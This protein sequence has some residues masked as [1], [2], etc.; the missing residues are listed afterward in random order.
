MTKNVPKSFKITV[1]VIVPLLIYAMLPSLSSH[2]N[3][4]QIIARITAKLPYLPELH[5]LFSRMPLITA[6]GPLLLLLAVLAVMYY[7]RLSRELREQFDAQQ[8]I[9][10]QLQKLHTAVEHAPLSIVITDST[11]VIEY[12]NPAFCRLT[13]YSIEE[14]V[15]QHTRILKGEGAGTGEVQ[16]PEHYREL[17]KTIL[18]G[19]EWHGEFFNRRK[20]NTLFW[21]FASISPI[22]D[23]N[24][25]V[26]HFVAVKENITERKQMMEGLGQLAYHDKL[27]S[28]PNRALFLDRLNQ[29][30]A[31]SKC[32]QQRFAVLFVDLDG[33]KQVNDSYGHEAGDLVLKETA[34]RLA[35]CL[36]ATDIVARIGGDEFIIILRNINSPE[37]CG[38][39]AQKILSEVTRAIE[40]PE[41]RSCVIGSSIGISIYPEDA[42]E[43]MKL[44]N[45]ADTAM[46]A[47]KRN[48]KNEYRFYGG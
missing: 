13:G 17:W 47:V 33:F 26:T 22:R 27:T 9:S 28:L 16:P 21:E 24:G 36:R 4:P 44:V 42:Q 18:A 10:M 25:Q 20:D 32:E 40:L 23:G 39:V 29:A 43:A 30:I 6:L 8:R 1:V 12:V 3:A 46:Y 35:R 7:L 37:D 14:A 48:G 45:A 31:V 38:R 19:K 2:E 41:G 15:G 5:R 11:G 34:A